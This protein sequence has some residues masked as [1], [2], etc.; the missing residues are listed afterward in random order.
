MM[1]LAT[2]CFILLLC[3]DVFANVEKVI[4]VAPAA[5]SFPTDASID[6]LLLATLTEGEPSIRTHLNA[7]FPT[8]NAPKGNETWML[9][10][11]LTP[12]RRYE[13]RICW[14]AT[15]G[16]PPILVSSRLILQ[17][18]TA[19]WLYTHPMQAVFSDPE[20][21]SSLTSYSYARHAIIDKSEMLRFQTASEQRQ[22][23]GPTKPTSFLFLQISA[24]ADYYTLNKTLMDNVPPVH[25]DV[26]LDPYL[27]NVFPKSLLLTG[28][29]LVIIA[30]VGWFLSGWCWDNLVIPFAAGAAPSTDGTKKDD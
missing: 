10:E 28:V 22:A 24:A 13:V 8:E 17:Q 21:L 7:S 19:F 29:Y 26:I 18:P 1:L 4:F 16:S 20:L 3:S 9:L 25:A 2:I 30:V 27:L 14:L 15:V 23:L 6:N 5:E 11:G 12:E